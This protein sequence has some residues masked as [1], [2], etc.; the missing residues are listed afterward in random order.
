MFID[1]TIIENVVDEFEC[2]GREGTLPD[3]EDIKG[4][5]ECLINDIP[6]AGFG[7]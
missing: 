7:G 1:M 2:S 4:L 3:N 5:A 6:Y